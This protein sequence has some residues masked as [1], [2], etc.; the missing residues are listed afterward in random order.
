M[1]TLL[2]MSLV[3]LVGCKPAA[4]TDSDT[5]T[6]TDTPTPSDFPVS[7][8]S[9][10]V[11][12]ALRAGIDG[13]V[14]EEGNF[15]VLTPD[16]C[17]PVLAVKG[18]CLGNNPLTP[19][20]S[21]RFD[22]PAGYAEPIGAFQLEP[23]EAV[24]FVGYTPPGRYWSWQAHV[25][26]REYA[27]GDRRDIV[28]TITPSL[29]NRNVKHEG[30]PG[31]FGV[32]TVAIW[33]PNERLAQA[34]VREIDPLLASAGVQADIVNVLPI[35]YLT[36]EDIELTA[37]DPAYADITVTEMRMGYESDDDI[38]GIAV[39]IAGIADDDPYLDVAHTPLVPFKISLV[40]EPEYTPF[41]YPL[42]PPIRNG[43]A[44]P[45]NGFA[46]SL[47]LVRD[48]VQAELVPATDEILALRFD[49]LDLDGLKCVDRGL[50]CGNSDDVLYMQSPGARLAET[51]P[52]GMYV[53]GGIHTALPEIAGSAPHLAYSGIALRNV[54]QRMGIVGYYDVDLRGTAE[55]WFPSGVEGVPAD[56]LARIFVWKLARS[57]EGT[58]PLCTAIGAGP[59]EVPNTHVFNITS[60]AYLDLGTNTGPHAAAIDAPWAVWYG[61]EVDFRPL[62]V[63][64]E[65]P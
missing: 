10:S 2:W 40:E 21:P 28:S 31:G 20:L 11:V 59:E 1:C 13:F 51:S 38:Y 56:H 45:P 55:A 8:Y 25:H 42:I 39:R 4:P 58:E 24:V 44:R 17:G 54:D 64:V 36:P 49:T 57:C 46:E 34:I 6:H 9:D 30:P 23:D 43:E 27:P 37:A 22:E 61:P 32:Y 14:I 33:S 5:D 41:P 53:I 19:Y 47:R 35:P 48:A 60:R 15:H 50:A 7:D 26:S 65:I 63:V 62:Q 16:L 12:D 52:G 3:G 18:T 29:H